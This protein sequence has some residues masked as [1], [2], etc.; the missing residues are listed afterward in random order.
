MVNEDEFDEA[1]DRYLLMGKK[2]DS[3]AGISIYCALLIAEK[4]R[5]DSNER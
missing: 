1:L 5:E 2:A 3:N 4:I